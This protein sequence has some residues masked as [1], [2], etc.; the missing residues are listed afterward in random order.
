MTAVD[1]VD[2]EIAAGEFFSMLG[3]SGSGKTTVLRLIAG[4]EQPTSGT[5][6]LFG[7]DVTDAGAVRPRRQHGL[8]GLRALPAHERARQRRLRPAGARHRPQAS[9]ASARSRR[10][11]PCASRTSPTASRRSSRAVSV[12]ASRSRA[13]PSSSRRCCCSTSRSGALDLKLREQMQ[14]E[15][16][17][18]QRDLG[19]TFIFVTHDQEEAL[20]LSRPHRGVQRGPHRAARHAARALRAAGIPLRR[21]LR[22]HLEPVRRRPLERS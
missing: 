7:Q 10:S 16:K 3:P 20:T 12:S 4:F 17:Q 22:R 8:P 5:I 15:L 6:E 11:P 2:L 9:G 18:I 21:R 14:V 19:I 1:H 13:P